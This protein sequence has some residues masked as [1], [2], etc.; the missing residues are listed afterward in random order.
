ME[1]TD[2]Q[3]AWVASAIDFE[4]SI[5]FHKQK[6]PKFER[7]FQWSVE[8]QMANTDKRL[9][10]QFGVLCGQS[11]YY[12]GKP[13]S[14]H[15]KPPYRIHITP[16]LLRVILPKV[17]PYLIAKKRQAELAIEALHLIKNG[18]TDMN[19]RRLEEIYC[20]MTKNN[21]RGV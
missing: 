4:S 15:A 12:I 9:I 19:A 8:M 7:G 18:F 16:K 10:E 21:K 14:I 3:L 1:I 13:A 2:I 5:S 11:K 6:R 17:L 20:E